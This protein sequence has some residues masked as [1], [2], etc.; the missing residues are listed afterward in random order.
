MLLNAAKFQVYNFYRFC[1]TKEKLA[2]NA[3]GGD[4]LSPL[5]CRLRLTNFKN[6]VNATSMESGFGMSTCYIH[7]M[8]LSIK[9]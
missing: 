8:L 3:G 2:R 6:V 9:P 1:V 7:M 5:Q 4:T